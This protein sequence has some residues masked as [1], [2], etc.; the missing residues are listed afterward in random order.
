M[1]NCSASDAYLIEARVSA[2]VKKLLCV[3]RFAG[4]V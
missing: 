1:Q 3:T 2:Q 4:G